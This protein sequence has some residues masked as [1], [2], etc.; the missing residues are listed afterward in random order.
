MIE[1][2]KREDLPAILS[3][4]RLAYLSEAELYDGMAIPR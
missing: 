4:Q 3:L 1:R 2:A